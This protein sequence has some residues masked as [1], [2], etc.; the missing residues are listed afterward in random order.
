MTAAAAAAIGFFTVGLHNNNIECTRLLVAIADKK[1]TTFYTQTVGSK[2][3]KE[4]EKLLE[5]KKLI[6]PK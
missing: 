4:R 6:L 1:N 2:R 3:E 5:K